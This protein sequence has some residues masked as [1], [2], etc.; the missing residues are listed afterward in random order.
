MQSWANTDTGRAWVPMEDGAGASAW[1]PRRTAMEAAVK[2]LAWTGLVSIPAMQVV[3]L[4]TGAVVWRSSDRYPDSGAPILPVWHV[5]AENAA[6]AELKADEA[7][8]EPIA[9]PE[10]EPDLLD[11]L[12]ATP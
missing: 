6:Q 3:D 12:G 8:A 4:D 11:L 9:E 5:H 2:C 1:R 10:P 7:P